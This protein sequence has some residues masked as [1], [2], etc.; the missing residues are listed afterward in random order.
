MKRSGLG[1]NKV[2]YDETKWI[3]T[4]PNA[5]RQLGLNSKSIGHCQVD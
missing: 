4:T 2:D 3:R 1:Q 5:A